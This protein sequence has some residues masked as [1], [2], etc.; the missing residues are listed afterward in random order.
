MVQVASGL[1]MSL[2]NLL[3]HG[4]IDEPTATSLF[5]SSQLAQDKDN[6]TRIKPQCGIIRSEDVRSLD[7]R[8]MA[9]LDN[10]QPGTLFS[11]YHCVF[12]YV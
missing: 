3:L 5:V 6:N 4:I 9:F 1:Y 12:I 2:I 10:Y 11:L 7:A 8:F